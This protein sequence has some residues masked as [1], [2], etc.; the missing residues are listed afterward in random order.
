[1]HIYEFGRSKKKMAEPLLLG[2]ASE[3]G[4]LG[5]ARVYSELQEVFK[6]ITYTPFKIKTSK[7]RISNF[8]LYLSNTY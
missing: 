8:G 5:C 2:V 7:S 3:G 4:F 6:I 1:M